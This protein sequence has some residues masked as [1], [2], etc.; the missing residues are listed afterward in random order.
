M[1]AL[2]VLLAL[3]LPMQLSW[4]AVA[5]HCQEE[6]ERITTHLGHH[7]HPSATAEAPTGTEKPA[8]S[9]SDADCSLC[10]FSCIKSVEICRLSVAVPLAP[11]QKAHPAYLHHPASH[12]AEGPD[13]PNWLLAA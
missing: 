8:P 11:Q 7:E 1:R 6:S 2:I 5:A 3:L 13:K 9:V 4:A 12:I 10:H